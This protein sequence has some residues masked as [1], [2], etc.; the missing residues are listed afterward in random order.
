MGR[1]QQHVLNHYLQSDYTITDLGT[2]DGSNG[3]T[4]EAINDNGQ[5]VGM[6]GASASSG[7]HAFLWQDGKMTD[8]GTR[9]RY[10][11]EARAI[12]NKGQIV[13]VTIAPGIQ[14]VEL[15]RAFIWQNGQMSDMGTLGGRGSGAAAIDDDGQVVGLSDTDPT[16]LS[17]L[18]NPFLWQNGQMVA[19]KP[20]FQPAC[21][22]NKGII[23]G[24]IEVKSDAPNVPSHACEWQNGEIIDLGTLPD[25]PTDMS[26]ANSINDKGQVVGSSNWRA[27]L[28][29]NGVMTNL[30]VAVQGS[31]ASAINNS[32]QVV[33]YVKVADDSRHAYL[34]QNGQKIDLNSLLPPGSDWELQEAHGINNEGQIVGE[35][36]HNAKLRAFLM[37]PQ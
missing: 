18:R 24:S 27:F 8:L 26:V 35:G 28:W 29:Q 13:G 9:G 10:A 7:S 31:D 15:Y 5:V 6:I 33:G 32:G 16:G 19:L 21:I 11:S 1:A 30:D 36:N 4:A 23:V 22:N 12:N 14:D 3:S 34:W 17:H 2:L 20:T 25:Q 37:T